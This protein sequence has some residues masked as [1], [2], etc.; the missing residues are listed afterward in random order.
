LRFDVRDADQVVVTAKTVYVCV[1][2]DG[3]GSCEIPP[4]VLGGL[5]APTG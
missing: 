4:L 3:S 2:T 1:R 5:G